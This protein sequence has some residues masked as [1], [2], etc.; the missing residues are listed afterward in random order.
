MILDC[1]KIVCAYLA[2]D[3]ALHGGVHLLAY[4]AASQ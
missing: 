2:V 3:G 1:E 4:Q